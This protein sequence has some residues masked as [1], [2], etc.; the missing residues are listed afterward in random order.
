MSHFTPEFKHDILTQYLPH[1]HDNSFGAL[2]HRYNIK[3]GK[4]TIQR[5]YARWDGT[6]S[7]LEQ[8]AGAGRPRLLSSA[9]IR[10]TIALPI[11][12]RNRA[13]R[14]IHYTE[15]LPT[16]R[17]RTG[18]TVSLPTIQ[19]YGKEIV[20]ARDKSTRSRTAVDCKYK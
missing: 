17:E 18:T 16:V 8:R 12:N 9:Q 20:R 6:P 2:A 14:A 1:S 15:L 7:S 10:D 5:W 11:R 3:G 19:R 4:R 13:H